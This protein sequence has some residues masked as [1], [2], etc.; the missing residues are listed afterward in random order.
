MTTIG[1]TFYSNSRGHIDPAYNGR[2]LSG[3]ALIDSYKEIR[4]NP[5]IKRIK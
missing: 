5:Y 2:F 1:P 4:E 3:I